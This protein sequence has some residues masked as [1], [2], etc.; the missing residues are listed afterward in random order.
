MIH[1]S[2]IE[3][4]EQGLAYMGEREN[5]AILEGLFAGGT[6]K[7]S[8]EDEHNVRADDYVM[9]MP[10][11]G[12]RIVGRDRMRAFQEAYPNPPTMKL[13]R[14]IGSGDLFV[15]EGVSDYG[16]DVYY[17]TDVVEFRDGKIAK[18]TRYYAIP[19]E[20]PEWRA[21]WVERIS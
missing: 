3:S 4:E 11:S 14:I 10:Q 6:L 18:E 1:A 9:E 21:Q 12:E 5:R 15:M 17:V 20:A 7:L 13:L 16:G 8:P 19:F 2:D